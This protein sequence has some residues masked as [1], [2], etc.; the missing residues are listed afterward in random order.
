MAGK[1][2]LAGLARMDRELNC[3]HGPRKA[4][5]IGLSAANQ[6]YAFAEQFLGVVVR[7]GLYV[8][9]QRQGHGAAIAGRGEHTHDF[10]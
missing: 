1:I 8:L 5:L 10:G 9:R 6:P 4:D 2:G 7:L 3:F